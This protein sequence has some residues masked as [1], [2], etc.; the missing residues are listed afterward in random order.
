MEVRAGSVRVK[1]YRAKWKGYVAY[2]VAD[3]S[4]GKRKLRSFADLSAAKAEAER[5]AQ[6]LARGE[7]VA[8]GIGA[9]ERASYS[10]AVE[11][12]TPTGLPFESAAAVVAEAF[13]VLGGNRILE[14]CRDFARRN[15]AAL[16]P[17]PVREAVADFLAT[18][19]QNGVS[20]RYVA[21]LTQKLNKLSQAFDGPLS[22]L[23]ADRLQTWLDGN[24][25]APATFESY[26]RVLGTFAGFCVRK[27]WLPHGW[28]EIDRIEKPKRKPSAIEIYSP[29]E[30]ARL[31][32]VAD[33]DFVPILAIAALA[34]IRSAEI[35]RLTWSDI[36]MQSGFITVGAAQAKT[37]SRR[38]VPIAENLKAWLAPYVRESGRIWPR[39]A[40]D[41]H[42]QQ[43]RTAKRAVMAWKK[44][45]CRHSFVSY[46]LAQVQDA[47]KVSLEA[48]NSPRMV[49]RHY[50]E[51]VRP[52]DATK[53]FS[54]TPQSRPDTV[55]VG[56]SAV[57]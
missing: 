47:G 10:R 34:G 28:D 55:A 6:K 25:L 19:G 5:I 23:T 17:K 14:A 20:T 7:V 37:A 43:A 30:L 27:R 56:A 15:P 32:A 9:K 24:T 53:W 33:A 42:W 29:D 1:I 31:F 51:L 41:L 4:E 35:Q 38:I 52:T 36:D 40:G 16:P 13:K 46:R 26:C 3:Y 57:A 45:A 11:L 54:I 2:Q 50:R 44:N 21:D 18:K 12:L 39:S 8:A 49:F 22:S 48:G